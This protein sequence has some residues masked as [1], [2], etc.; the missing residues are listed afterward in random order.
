[1]RFLKLSIGFG[2]C[3][4]ASVACSSQKPEPDPEPVAKPIPAKLAPQDCSTCYRECESPWDWCLGEEFYGCCGES[5]CHTESG[6]DICRM[7]AN[8]NCGEALNECYQS[9]CHWCTGGSS[10]SYGGE[11]CGTDMDCCSYP[12]QGCSDNHI[13]S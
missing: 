12:Y 13:C 10:C 7:V 6:S 9:R 5:F 3:G 1:M 8:K 2:I 11:P 4:I